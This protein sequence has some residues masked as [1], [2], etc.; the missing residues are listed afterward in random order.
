MIFPSL[1][2]LISFV[3]GG[4]AVGGAVANRILD[5]PSDR[6]YSSNVVYAQ[7]APVY[8]P[9]PVY[10]PAP[11]AQPVPVSQPVNQQV[12]TTVIVQQPRKPEDCYWLIPHGNERRWCLG[13]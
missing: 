6:H 10:Q 3:G 1:I 12:P 7:P 2:I 9:S 5:G 8:Q 11:V 4:F 13:H